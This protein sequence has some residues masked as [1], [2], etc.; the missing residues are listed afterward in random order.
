MQWLRT[1]RF[2]WLA[3][4]LL[5]LVATL[6]ALL[7]AEVLVRVTGRAPAFLEIDLDAEASLYRR[8]KNPVL[9]YELKP[10][11]GQDSPGARIVTNSHGQRDLPR[12]LEKPAGQLRTIL[13]GD[14]V[15]QGAGIAQLDATISQ[16]L[17]RL[18]ADP[19]HEV[20]NFG[21]DGYCTRAEVEL[22]EVKGVRFQPD[23]VVLLFVEN[24]F[25]NFNPEV[26]RLATE[27]PVIANFLFRRSALFRL[28]AVQ[29]NL[30]HFSIESDPLS[31]HAG[32]IGDN[33]VVTGLSHLRQLAD[34]HQFEVVIAIWPRFGE[35]SIEDVH[36]V[37]GSEELVIER[38]AADLQMPTVRLSK[39]FAEHWE[40]IGKPDTPRRTYTS[41]DQMHPSVLGC[42]VAAGF[43]QTILKDLQA[44]RLRPAELSGGGQGKI[45]TATAQLA[46]E[47]GTRNR[48]TNYPLLMADADNARQAEGG[49]SRAELLYRRAMQ[50]KPDLPFAYYNL[51]TL[52]EQAGRAEEARTLY[53]KASRCQPPHLES[54]FNLAMLLMR[55]GEFGKAVEHLKQV[56]S[57]EP[58]HLAAHF[59]LGLIYR[60][61]G[62]NELARQTF[63]AILQHH[64][65][66]QDAA[67]MLRELDRGG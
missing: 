16:Q 5:A 56:V 17:E 43:L 22:L 58:R 21:V 59:N 39:H 27:R 47:L 6:L 8:S 57:I 51:A 11:F 26:E 15:V 10:S 13:L 7:V 50:L 28:A 60:Q 4:P 41:G 61:S 44:G 3:R 25:D 52:L 54:H 38:L 55:G 31:W 12:K 14:S 46:K 29:L 23:H 9:A 45:E 35:K 18:L 67:R 33:N 24:D 36:Q 1:T 49:L 37:P 63:Q 2:R 19:A 20:L 48:P 53:A 65:E 30:F 66:H 34:Q 40:S 42:Q 64:P 32:A 62:E